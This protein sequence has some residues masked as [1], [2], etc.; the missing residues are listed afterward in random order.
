[1]HLFLPV[2]RKGVP[3]HLRNVRSKLS[4]T[5]HENERYNLDSGKGGRK[6][7]CNLEPNNN[8]CVYPSV[9]IE[10]WWKDPYFAF[11]G[12][13]LFIHT[14]IFPH[15]LNQVQFIRNILLNPSPIY[16]TF[17]TI[18]LC[19]EEEDS[20]VEDSQNSSISKKSWVS[21]VYNDSYYNFPLILIN[22]FQT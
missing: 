4:K 21:K 12:S 20:G 9:C 1:M 6:Y 19:L 2:S 14:F 7:E 3:A 11:V 5:F 15:T 22:I 13:A 8:V 10:Y 18:S 17:F 16:E